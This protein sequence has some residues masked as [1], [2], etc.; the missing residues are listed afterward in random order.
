MASVP[1]KGSYVRNAPST[2]R[3]ACPVLVVGGGVRCFNHGQLDIYDG[4]F[5]API[6][7]ALRVILSKPLL[8]LTPS[9]SAV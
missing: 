6:Y 4:C 3:P 8:R 7:L 5:F 2:G 1:R 9:R